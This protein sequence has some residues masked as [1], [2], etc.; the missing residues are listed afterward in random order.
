M[1]GWSWD[2]SAFDPNLTFVFDEVLNLRRMSTG[3]QTGPHRARRPR[4]HAVRRPVAAGRPARP[5]PAADSTRCGSST[6]DNVGFG[7]DAAHVRP[8]AAHGPESSRPPE[9]RRLL[10]RGAAAVL[11]HAPSIEAVFET[12]LPDRRR[13]E[14]NH[15]YVQGVDPAS[16]LRLRRGRSSSTSRSPD[17]IGGRCRVDRRAADRRVHRGLATMRT[18]RTTRARRAPARRPSTP[19]AS[20]ARSSA[21]LLVGHQSGHCRR[22]RRDAVRQDEDADQPADGARHRDAWCFPRSGPWL[23][24]APSAAGLQASID[25]G[26][27]PTP[28]WPWPWPSYASATPGRRRTRSRRRS[29]TSASPVQCTLR[30]CPV[31]R[32][33]ASA[34]DDR[35]SRR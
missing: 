21:S 15:Q 22:V 14:S 24:T 4:A 12:E 6:R 19:R 5:R 33:E 9:H 27:T 20:A 16:D 11:R 17:W 2:E 29:T 13:A 1:N 26:S 35:S 30:R 10:H 32:V 23:A 8:H 7:I 3:G 25:K 18:S 31:P 28:S 34:S